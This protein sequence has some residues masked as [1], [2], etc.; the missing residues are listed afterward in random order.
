MCSLWYQSILIY[1]TPLIKRYGL[2]FSIIEIIVSFHVVETLSVFEDQG[3][4]G[5]DILRRP[6]SPGYTQLCPW[7]CHKPYW[8]CKRLNL[9][10]VSSGIHKVNVYLKLQPKCNILVKVLLLLSII[11]FNLMWILAVLQITTCKTV[12]NKPCKIV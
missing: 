9:K 11:I 4:F 12:I 5:N 7:R 3:H 2:V 6:C 1:V 10:P 8:L